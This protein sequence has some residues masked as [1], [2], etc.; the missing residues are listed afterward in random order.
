M[1]DV[2]DTKGERV[3]AESRGRLTQLIAM[4]GSEGGVEEDVDLQHPDMTMS[5]CT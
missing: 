3:T 2:Y 5:L 4:A 1:L